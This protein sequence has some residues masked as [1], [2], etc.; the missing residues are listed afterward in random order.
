MSRKR[1][2]QPRI[3]L[4]TFL[5]VLICTM[6]ALIVLLSL[7]IA[8]AKEHVTSTVEAEVATQPEVDPEELKRLAEQEEDLQWRANM[9]KEQREQYAKDLAD[10]RL[11]L[12]HLEDHIRRLEDQAKNLIAQV[13]ELKRLDS[14]KLADRDGARQQLEEM[15]KEISA[16]RDELDK[17]KKEA[18]RRRPAYAIV[19]YD[20]PNGTSRRP[21]YIECSEQGVLLQPEGVRLAASD[22]QGPMGPGNPL[23][24]ALRAMREYWQ[25][26]GLQGE[27]YPLIVVRPDGAVAFGA[28]RTAMKHW[29]SEFGYELVDQDAELK[30]PPA[31]RQLAETLQRAVV[32]ARMRQ[33]ALAAAMPRRF[34]SEGRLNSF[35]ASDNFDAEEMDEGSGSGPGGT[36]PGGT[37]RGVPSFARGGTGSGTGPNGAA[38]SGGSGTSGTATSLGGQPP[39]GPRGTGRGTGGGPYAGTGPRPGGA[40]GTGPAGSYGDAGGGNSNSGGS[41]AASGRTASGGPN[42]AAGGSG[43]GSP[44]GTSA[45]GSSTASGANGAAGGT[46]GGTAARGAASGQ[47]GGSNPSSSGAQSGTSGAGGGGQQSSQQNISMQS[48]TPTATLDMSPQMKKA[49]KALKNRGENWGLPNSN[50]K[51]TGVM[52]PIAMQCYEDQ[53]VL[54]PEKGERSTPLVVPIEDDLTKNLDAVVAAVWQRMD[55]WGLAVSGGYWK[56]VLTIDVQPGGEERFWELQQLLRGSG[57]EVEKKSP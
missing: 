36:G 8:R 41:N 44:N 47:A 48:G 10:K 12:A 18:L 55:R 5:D 33:Q 15:E 31:D 37:G 16:K 39:A 43:S 40:G 7:L 1:G 51:A 38:G 42:A 50:H 22:F 14:N 24:A 34:G 6:G 54:L 45:N 28:C 56:P 52:R 27:P 46:P 19:P 4:F 49:R 2:E 21:M 20:G 13:E 35:R 25:Q 53:L 32:D 9:L 30:F 23:D 29:E 17:A 11:E 57:I 3:P 26:H